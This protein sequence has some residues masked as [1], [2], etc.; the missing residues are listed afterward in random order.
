MVTSAQIQAVLTQRGKTGV[1]LVDYTLVDRS[2]GQGAQIAQWN[3]ATLGPLPTPA[4]LAAVTP[5]QITAA[6][7]AQTDGAAALD[8]DQKVL[9]ALAMA[10]WECIPA[11]T[12]TKAQLRARCIAIWKTL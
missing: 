9:K 6:Q 4:E 5:A 12:M 8:V 11:P 3:T 7:T 10:L 1:S 2:D